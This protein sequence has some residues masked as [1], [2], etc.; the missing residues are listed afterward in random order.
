MISTA[1]NRFRPQTQEEVISE[2]LLPIYSAAELREKDVEYTGWLDVS[3]HQLSAVFGVLAMGAL[4][5][6]TLKVGW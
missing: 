4:G 5:D 3:P 2:Y 1:A 6:L